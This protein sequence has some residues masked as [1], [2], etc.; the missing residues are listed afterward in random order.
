MDTVEDLFQFHFVA[1]HAPWTATPER[2]INKSLL[3]KLPKD[4]A[5]INAGPREVMH[6]GELQEFLNERPDVCFLCGGAQSHALEAE[7]SAG[8]ESVLRLCRAALD[9]IREAAMV[10]VEP[11]ER[12]RPSAVHPGHQ[13]R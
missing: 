6:E 7:G 13:Q 9:K 1:L 3:V 2:S 11:A 4:G 8:D 12:T 10:P 5:L